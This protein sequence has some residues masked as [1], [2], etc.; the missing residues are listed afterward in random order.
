MANIKTIEHM[1]DSLIIR[2]KSRE[3]EIKGSFY[4][5]T[6]DYQ[7]SILSKPSEKHHNDSNLHPT[8][9]RDNKIIFR[10]GNKETTGIPIK[11]LKKSPK[12]KPNQIDAIVADI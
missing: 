2:G 5:S 11:S 12:G 7:R 3:R 9:H 10:Y 6:G 8:T 1:N 4:E